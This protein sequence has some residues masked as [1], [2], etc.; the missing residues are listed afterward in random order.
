MAPEQ[1]R[2]E[3]TTPATDVFALALILYEL[4]TGRQA[5]GDGSLIEML[6]RLERIDPGRY[7]AEVPEPFASILRQAL[8]PNPD[9]RIVTME[10]IATALA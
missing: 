5:I 9:R 8:I 2:G 6:Q 4:A 10:Q 7:A 3:A 1:A